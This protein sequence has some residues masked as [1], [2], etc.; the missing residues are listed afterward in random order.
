LRPGLDG[1]GSNMKSDEATLVFLAGVGNSGETHW[2]RRWAGGF[3]KTF[4]LEHSEWDAPV[5]NVWTL[6]MEEAM[7]AVSGPKLLVCHSLGCLLASEWSRNHQD[8]EVVGAFLVAVPDPRSPSFPA[9]V[10]GYGAHDSTALPF[11]SLVV[12][13]TDDPY[14]SVTYAEQLAS[15]WGSGFENVGTKGHINAASD[16]GMWNEGINLMRNYFESRSVSLP[17]LSLSNTSL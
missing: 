4:W 8:A 15:A 7:K 3:A 13:S 9:E 10:R 12:A 5:C 17:R 6:E 14:A 11:P 2:Q 1:A 16:L